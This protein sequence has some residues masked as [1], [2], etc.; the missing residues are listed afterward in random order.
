MSIVYYSVRRMFHSTHRDEQ[1]R[2]LSMTASMLA[3][4]A[5]LDRAGLTGNGLILTYI[6]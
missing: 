2:I 4:L 1:Q 3:M 6:H 5:M